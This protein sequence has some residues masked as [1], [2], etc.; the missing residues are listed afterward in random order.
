MRQT[1]I[2]AATFFL[3]V[4]IQT[5]FLAS[6][7]SP[8][9][10]VPLLFAA[11]IW[12]IQQEESLAGA[13]WLIGFG[14]WLDVWGIGG[15]PASTLAYSATAIAAVVSARR[16]FTHR[17]LY[18]VFSCACIAL[19]ARAGAEVVV[20]FAVGLRNPGAVEWG[21]WA[22]ARAWEA[23]FCLVLITGIYQA[24]KPL[25]NVFGI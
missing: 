7:P 22:G 3:L 12:L 24:S 8:F 9:N 20:Q 17:S 4:V 19:L 18:G 11:S 23:L 10:Y 25:R 6:L 1:I 2:W 13:A 16:L 5:S 15:L 14:F 21:A